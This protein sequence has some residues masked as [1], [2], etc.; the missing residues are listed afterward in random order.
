MSPLQLIRQGLLDNNLDK[1][2]QGYEALTG[3]KISLGDV[4][5][6]V[7]FINPNEYIEKAGINIAEETIALAQEKNKQEEEALAAQENSLDIEP[8]AP[9]PPSSANSEEEIVDDNEEEIVKDIPKKNN[10]LLEEPIGE[11]ESQNTVGNKQCIRVPFLI[12]K[13]KN[14]F[15]D[16]TAIAADDTIKFDKK[17]RTSSSIAQKSNIDK[18]PAPVKIVV[19]CRECHRKFRVDPL[20]VPSHVGGDRATYQCDGCRPKKRGG[21]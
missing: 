8:F 16:N 5:D 15:K 2:R 3:E 17:V 9:P 4:A 21:E 7:Q 12:G 13:R 18:R 6:A 19:S 11:D 20:F 10:S 14:R 1:I